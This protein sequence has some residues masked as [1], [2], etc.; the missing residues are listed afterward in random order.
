MSLDKPIKLMTNT[1]YLK[2]KCFTAFVLQLFDPYIINAFY[3]FY[4]TIN[5]ASAIA[6]VI[7]FTAAFFLLKTSTTYSNGD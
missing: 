7:F 6:T 1:T 4:Y 3:T 5:N 2:G